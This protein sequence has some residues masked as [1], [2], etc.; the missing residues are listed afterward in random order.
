MNMKPV[1][2]EGQKIGS[3]RVGELVLG[4]FPN[5]RSRRA[6]RCTCKCGAVKLVD[7]QAL[8]LKNGSRMCVPCMNAANIGQASP[9]W[10]GRG[11]ITGY[12]WSRIVTFARV[13]D[14]PIE[15]TVEDG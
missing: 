2:L 4:R 13:R 5:G 9:V 11:E 3:W 10:T 8:L 6:Y 15:V 1:N 12:V 7:S 14:I